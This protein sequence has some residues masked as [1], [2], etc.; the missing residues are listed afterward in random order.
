M[1]T[2]TWERPDKTFMRSDQER[3]KVKSNANGREGMVLIRRLGRAIYGRFWCQGKIWLSAEVDGI[4]GRGA[5][6][7][8]RLY[9]GT[10][11]IPSA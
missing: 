7:R 8:R 11:L 3:F 4:E 9:G 6:R 1:Y 2:K 10:E 5:Y